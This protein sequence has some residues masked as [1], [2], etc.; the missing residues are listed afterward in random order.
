MDGEVGESFRISLV[1]WM[2]GA[3]LA[4]IVGVVTFTLLVYNRQTGKYADAMIAASESSVYELVTQPFV[5]GPTCYANISAS[6]GQVNTV[7]VKYDG[8]SA[9]TKVYDYN[10]SYDN[11][12]SLMTGKNATRNFRVEIQNHSHSTLIDVYLTEVKR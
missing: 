4:V 2:T 8:Q 7:Y 6:I 3:F 11:T 5:S 1:V 9:N 10:T 12:I